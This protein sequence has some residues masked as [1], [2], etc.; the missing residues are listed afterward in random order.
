MIILIVTSFLD[1]LKMNTRWTSKITQ[2]CLNNYNHLSK[3]L[4]TLIAICDLEHF[5]E[6]RLILPQ[7]DRYCCIKMDTKLHKLLMR[8]N[9]QPKITN[10]F[11]KKTSINQCG[12]I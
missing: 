10:K 1:G 4:K 11:Y 5:A 12:T 7:K 3:Q 9:L 6:L 8:L 2:I